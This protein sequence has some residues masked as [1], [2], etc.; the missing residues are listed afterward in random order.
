MIEFDKD[1]IVNN[2]IGPKRFKRLSMIWDLQINSYNRILR[3]FY[4]ENSIGVVRIY[5]VGIHK[6]IYIYI[7]DKIS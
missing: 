3:T 7:N 1:K 4:C 5:N 2:K 6:Y